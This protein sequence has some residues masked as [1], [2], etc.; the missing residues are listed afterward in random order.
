MAHGLFGGPAGT[1]LKRNRVGG[2]RP[3]PGQPPALADLEPRPSPAPSLR[4]MPCDPATLFWTVHSSCDK[5]PEMREQGHPW[6]S[7]ADAGN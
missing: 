7:F 3:S 1:G 5:C 4:L 6:A 2:D